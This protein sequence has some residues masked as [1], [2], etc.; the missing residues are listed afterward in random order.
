VIQF[1]AALGL[2]SLGMGSLLAMAGIWSLWKHR[3]NGAFFLGMTLIL[4]GI[5]VLSLA[6]RISTSV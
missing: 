6:H 3:K 5:I 4:I 1:L 2:L